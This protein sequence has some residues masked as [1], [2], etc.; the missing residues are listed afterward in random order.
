M[1]DKS[2]RRPLDMVQYEI[3]VLFDDERLEQVLHGE[4][5]GHEF[6]I[7]EYETSRHDDEE[8]SINQQR[9]RFKHVEHT[10]DHNIGK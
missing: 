10:G 5:V 2:E 4:T 1:H 9:R 6:R 7:S 3:V 8:Q